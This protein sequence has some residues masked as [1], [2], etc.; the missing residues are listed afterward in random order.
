MIPFIT[1]RIGRVDAIQLYKYKIHY[2]CKKDKTQYAKL[3]EWLTRDFSIDVYQLNKN[4]FYLFEKSLQNS[5]NQ[6]YFDKSQVVS[7]PY[8]NTQQ[9][10]YYLGKVVR[11]ALSQNYK[12]FFNKNIFIIESKPLGDF[13]LHK[14]VQ[15]NIQVFANGQFMIHWLP[16]SQ[17]T[18]SS[19]VTPKYI[20]DLKSNLPKTNLSLSELDFHIITLDRYKTLKCSLD[21]PIS[22]IVLQT[23]S[24]HKCLATFDYHFLAQYS[25]KI[26]ADIT[27]NTA[28]KLDDSIEFLREVVSK[29]SLPDW[30]NMQLKPFTRFEPME[31]G[32]STNLLV[33][34][35]F[36]CREQKAAYHNGVYSSVNN[37]KILLLFHSSIPQHERT[38][39]YGDNFRSLFSEHFNKNGNNCV[40]LSDQELGE[41]ITL[42]DFNLLKK[43]YGNSLLIV[44]FTK[45]KIAE[46]LIAP[47]KKF[48]IKMQTYMGNYDRNKISNFIVKCIDKLGGL[49]CVIKDLEEPPHTYFIGIDLGHS[50]KGSKTF[51]NVAMVLFDQRGVFLKSVVHKFQSLNEALTENSLTSLLKL[52]FDYMQREKLELPQKIIYHRD[53][54]LHKS[55]IE[56]IISKTT[57]LFDI[58]NI[59]VVEIVK[60]GYPIMANYNEQ[61]KKYG[62][63]QSGTAYLLPE[64][65][66]AILCTNTQ[67]SGRNLVVNP[68]II[69]HKHGETEFKKII[70]HVF[71]FTR[72][73]TNNLYYST[74]LPATTLKANNVVGTSDKVWI[75]SYLG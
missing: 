46:S 63:P 57:E 66:Y 72:A 45:I 70:N 52:L 71:W 67:V 37:K 49:L 73:Y 65:K 28:K 42:P 5:I 62:S 68:I 50:T 41:N 8:E 58:H 61:D 22:N 18:S 39:T 2:L 51:T 20:H 4:S 33:G 36:A 60:S 7:P 21:K 74:R 40:F 10:S 44:L 29:T 64:Q 6:F 9:I 48:G 47:I 14:C 69:R 13:E 19:E 43:E 54:K 26:F 55:D 59:D 38:S 25:P 17:I 12:R 27:K 56:I 35:D 24:Q 23:I 1:T 53:G 11:N 75:S 34:N 16:V 30:L 3:M 15:F 32:H 31:L